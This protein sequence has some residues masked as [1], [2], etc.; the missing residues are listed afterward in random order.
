[1]LGGMLYRG[2]SRRLAREVS[3]FFSAAPLFP[4]PPPSHTASCAQL[5]LEH[6][7]WRHGTQHEYLTAGQVK[8]WESCTEIVHTRRPILEANFI[9][10]RNFSQTCSSGP[11]CCC[12][13]AKS[14]PALC[15]PMDCSSPGFLSFTFSQNLLRLMSSE[16][17]LS[18]NRLIFCRPLLLASLLRSLTWNNTPI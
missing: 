5:L 6:L 16:S 2:M 4:S 11:S 1:M 14:G 13:I 7:S 9:C 3:P 8:R 18:S 15:D 12:S 10:K 17:V